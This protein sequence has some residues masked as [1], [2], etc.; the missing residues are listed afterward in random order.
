MRSGS[1]TYPVGLEGRLNLLPQETEDLAD[2]GEIICFRQQTLMVNPN[3][4][5][6]DFSSLIGK[7]ILVS[8]KSTVFRIL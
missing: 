6:Q 4:P 8:A 3:L 1:T 2:F 7:Y 5:F